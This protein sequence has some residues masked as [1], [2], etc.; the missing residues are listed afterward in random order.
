M[1][2]PTWKYFWRLCWCEL[3]DLWK[4]FTTFQLLNVICASFFSSFSSQWTIPSNKSI[5]GP[6]VDKNPELK[7]LTIGLLSN[8][9][10]F[11]LL[12]CHTKI[13]NVKTR[14]RKEKKNHTSSDKKIRLFIENK[15]HLNEINGLQHVQKLNSC[16]IMW[17]NDDIF[18]YEPSNYLVFVT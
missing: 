17:M 11:Q 2:K 3:R 9:I 7:R 15:R 6:T 18:E 13:I 8:H 5:T 12:S 10:T 1:A 16:L 14:I 4:V